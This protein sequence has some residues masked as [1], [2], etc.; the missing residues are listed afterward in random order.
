M[1]ILGLH[2]NPDIIFH[3]GVV[4]GGQDDVLGLH[5]HHVVPQLLNCLFSLHKSNYIN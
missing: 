5:G 4:E 2:L 3:I 1:K